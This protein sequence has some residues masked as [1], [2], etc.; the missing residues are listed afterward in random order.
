MTTRLFETHIFP[1]IPLNG[2]F[3]T[4][5]IMSSVDYDVAESMARNLALAGSSCK[6]IDIQLTNE[7]FCAKTWMLFLV[8]F[9]SMNHS[10]VD[11][12]IRGDPLTHVQAVPTMLWHFRN[13]EKLTFIPS[14][15]EWRKEDWEA[16]AGALRHHSTLERL[17]VLFPRR[18]ITSRQFGF[19][20]S[21]SSVSRLKQLHLVGGCGQRSK[22][23]TKAET[24]PSS[25]SGGQRRRDNDI[26]LTLLANIIRGC[27]HLKTVFC[28]NIRIVG[29][30]S[31]GRSL[32]FSEAICNST[33]KELRLENCSLDE[34]TLT[35]IATATKHNPSIERL[36][37]SHAL[38]EDIC[39]IEL[40][41]LLDNNPTCVSFLSL[42]FL[43]Q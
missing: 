6:R 4:L 39:L 22:T 18:S 41:A 21:L 2:R 40:E 35:A 11:L 5:R 16:L 8:A 33:L 37:L 23:A 38:V 43:V 34:K 17:H 1:L 13:L 14:G 24:I 32:A 10:V 29:T 3:E 26:S 28:Q 27:R 7:K 25:S 9:R 36:Y 42:K 30:T 20:E 15:M 12:I 31:G 19:V